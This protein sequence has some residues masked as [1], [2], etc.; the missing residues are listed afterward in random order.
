MTKPIL[1][2]ILICTIPA[3]ARLPD[4]YAERMAD[5]IYRLEGGERAGVPYGIKSVKVRSKAHA[6][7]LCLQTIQNN[8]DRWLAARRPGHFF[9]FLANRYCPVASDPQGNANWRKNI[10]SIMKEKQ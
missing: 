5:A 1:A 8:H 10:H 6:R 9:D 2:T 3:N 7:L 4:D